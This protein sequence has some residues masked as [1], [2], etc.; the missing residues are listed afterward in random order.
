MEAAQLIAY[1]ES[2]AAGFEQETGEADP[3]I[4]AK[5]DLLK[6]TLAAREARPKPSA[7]SSA[8]PVE[9]AGAGDVEGVDASLQQ[10]AS[11]LRNIESALDEVEG[12][13]KFDADTK[14]F[15]AD[16]ASVWMPALS[17]ETAGAD[18][19]HQA[20]P[21]QEEDRALEPMEE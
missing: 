10:T 5:I 14:K 21:S 1:L 17:V 11:R 12:D 15:L 3:E 8:D 9:S 18:A 19:T 13:L 7:A 20:A 2:V 16:S 4:R 6:Q